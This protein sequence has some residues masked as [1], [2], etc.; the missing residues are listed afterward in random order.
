MRDVLDHLRQA[1]QRE[2]QHMTSLLFEEF[3]AAIRTG[4]QRWSKQGRILK[5]VLYGSYARG[6]WIDDP[7]GGY[8]SDYDI[9]IIVNDA[10][11]TDFELCSAAKDRLMRET[12]IAKTLSAPVSLIVHSLREVNQQLERGCPFFADIVD[13]GVALY[14]AEGF[15]FAQPRDLTAAEAILEAQQHSDYWMPLTLHACKLTITNI[16]DGVFRDAAFLFH[17]ATERLYHCTL[18][19]L[20]LYSPKSH[21]LN[22]LRSQCEQIAPRLIAAWLRDN[23]FARRCFELLRQA[24]VIARYSSHYEISDVELRWLG[25]RVE[26]LTEFVE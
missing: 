24:Y 26:V 7:V 15:H 22:F 8:R 20:S 18:L 13:Q 25:E 17:Q 3:D 12:T 1:K 16:S 5:V 6:D 23:R 2:L 9:L 19:T 14:E 4:T 11:L 21:R 10:R